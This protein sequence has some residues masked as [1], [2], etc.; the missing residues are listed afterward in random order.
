MDWIGGCV[1]RWSVSVVHTQIYVQVAGVC[2]MGE[3]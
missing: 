3:S 2:A 1:R